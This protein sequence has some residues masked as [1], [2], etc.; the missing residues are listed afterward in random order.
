MKPTPDH[1]HQETYHTL[2]GA[3]KSKGLTQVQLGK[4]TGIAQCD[5]SRMETGQANPSIKILKRLAAGMD[6]NISIEFLPA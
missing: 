5:I 3:R 1:P 6:M 2:I 4:K